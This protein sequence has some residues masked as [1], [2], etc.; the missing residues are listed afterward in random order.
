[1]RCHAMLFRLVILRPCRGDDD[2]D[3]DDQMVFVLS[4]V[5]FPQICGLDPTRSVIVVSLFLSIA[6]R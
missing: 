1:M 4:A 3:D 2:D 5:D 6:F